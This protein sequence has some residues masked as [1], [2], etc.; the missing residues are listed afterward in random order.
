LLGRVETLPL[1]SETARQRSGRAVGHT[2]CEL[3]HIL[4]LVM[5]VC[6]AFYM[7]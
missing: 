1:S 5:D 6:Q 4:H 2:L 7:L 3:G